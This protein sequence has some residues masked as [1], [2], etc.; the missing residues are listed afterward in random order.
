MP[1]SF[2]Y[3]QIVHS[4]ECV[5]FSLHVDLSPGPRR[6]DHH[7]VVR[8]V[9]WWVARWWC[10]SP[11]IS[12]DITLGLFQKFRFI[13]QTFY[14]C[15]Y[16]FH[17]IYNIFLLNQI[18]FIYFFLFLFLFLVIDWLLYSITSKS[19]GM[20]LFVHCSLFVSNAYV[21]FVHTYANT[22][23]LIWNSILPAVILYIHTY[24][25]FPNTSFLFIPTQNTFFFLCTDDIIEWQAKYAI[26]Y[27]SVCELVCLVLDI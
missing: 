22:L 20:Y 15:F 26:V 25:Y 14:V 24:I 19:S 27:Y 1:S 4:H 21:Y 8:G 16:I 18:I 2:S 12:T 13:Y 10:F 17:Y 6:Q 5:V 7:I 9:V 3:I 23:R 11:H